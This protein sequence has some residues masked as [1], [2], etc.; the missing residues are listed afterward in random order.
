[1][2]HGLLVTNNSNQVLVSSDTRNL[3][4]IGKYTEPTLDT[5]TDYYGGMRRFRYRVTCNVTPVPFFTMPT[6][7]YYGITGIRSVGN[8]EWDVEMLRSGTSAGYP[9][10][11]V[12]SDPRG[13]T[14]AAAFGMQVF[15]SD[16][17]VSF[18]SRMKPLAI[19]GGLSVTHPSNP[20][21][22]FPYS[23]S[24]DNCNSMGADA[25][26]FFEPTENNSFDVAPPP[27]KPMYHFSS[28]AQAEREASYHRSEQDCLGVD[29]YG[30]CW[31]YGT[32]E[33][34]TSWYWC[35]YRGGI[36][37]SSRTR[38]Y[39]WS[40]YSQDTILAGWIPCYFGCHWTYS[41]DTSLAG[42]GIGGDG[43]ASGSWPYA[44]ETINLSS[45]TV[46][47]A[48]ASRYD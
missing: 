13:K 17:T 6:N 15:N 45:A 36:K 33:N 27:S 4:F 19:S 10:L 14:P 48:D 12:F 38:F 5:S 23:L 2:T 42:I 30:T 31:G 1:M 7:D 37:K 21:P 11:Y 24:S 26:G 3:H 29:G 9:E 16:G 8:G 46:L 28:L 34:W 40:S 25:G 41:K 43:G 18:D 32:E 20:R 44:N 39:N 22:T 47:I 35:F